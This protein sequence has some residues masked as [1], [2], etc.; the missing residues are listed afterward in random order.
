EV[1]LARFAAD[2]DK[3]GDNRVF[4]W[5]EVL[6]DKGVIVMP[7]VVFPDRI[8]G[9]LYVAP[10]WQ[11]ETDQVKREKK[12]KKAEEERQEKEA[13]R[14][15]ALRTCFAITADFNKS[16]PK[17][18]RVL[19]NVP[20]YMMLD[21]HDVTDD[22]FLNPIW[23]R[24]VLGSRLGRA[25]LGNAMIAYALFQDWGNDPLAYR[26]GPKAELLDHVRDLFPE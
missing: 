15:S 14:P 9:H 3:P 20:T 18:Q 2:P 6:P 19:A 21:D 7:P 23:R 12:R 25:L 5:D 11:S 1:P 10:F 13:L 8:A 22:Y 17:V 26:S 16:L 4:F 24:R